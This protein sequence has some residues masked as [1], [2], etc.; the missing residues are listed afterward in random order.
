MLITDKDPHSPISPNAFVTR[1][2]ATRI[3]TSTGIRE[4]IEAI[5]NDLKHSPS[6]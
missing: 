3:L 2:T 6:R 1:K 5:L 4:C